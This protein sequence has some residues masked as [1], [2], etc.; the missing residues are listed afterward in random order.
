MTGIIVH[1][2]IGMVLFIPVGFIAGFVQDQRDQKLER[3]EQQMKEI[4]HGENRNETS[5]D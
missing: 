4:T 3:E 5:S 2:L 1:I